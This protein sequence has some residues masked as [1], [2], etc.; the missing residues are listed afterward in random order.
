MKGWTSIKRTHPCDISSPN[1]Y[2]EMPLT[3]I[4][5]YALPCPGISLVIDQGSVV[6]FSGDAIVNAANP[7]CLGG[8]GVDAVIS[9]L[10]GRAL[11]VDR[12]RL[13]IIS[14]DAVGRPVR[15]HVGG[16]VVTG[17]NRYGRL[18]PHIIHAVG[19]N[20]ATGGNLDKKRRLL[21][22]SYTQSLDIARDRGLGR[23]AFALLSAGVFRGPLSL[24]EIL[25]L[26]VEAIEAWAKRTSST[27]KLQEIH[28]CAFTP[29]ECHTLKDVC[30]HL[31]PAV[32]SPRSHRTVEQRNDATQSR[33]QF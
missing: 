20:F 29:T 14:V 1:R 6:D 18:P 23:I 2:C 12:S 3:E 16:A 9:Q 26:S 10:G 21:E 11:A 15:C 13:K 19:P 33:R 5:R 4:A 7:G 28:L 8:G 30:D 17:P 31:L 25:H 24:Q 27:I 32:V 22:S